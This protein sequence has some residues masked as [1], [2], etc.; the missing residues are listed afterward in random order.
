LDK[1]KEKS[2]NEKPKQQN[3][4]FDKEKE[5]NFVEKPKQQ[6]YSQRDHERKQQNQ[7]SGS[8]HLFY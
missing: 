7:K 3:H 4:N 2:V 5:K 1:E 8:F 6:T